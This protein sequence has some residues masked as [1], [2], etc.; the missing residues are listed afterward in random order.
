MLQQGVRL[1]K[2]RRLL[3]RRGVLV[4]YPTL[5][6]FA[7]AEFGFGRQATTIPL[8]DGEPGDELQLDTGWMTRL[9]PDLFGK[10]RR[11]R[12]WIFTPSRSRYRFVYP[13]FQETTATAIE[14]CE[15]AW[16]F[17]GG[18]FHTLVPD[19][20]SAI[21]DQADPLTPRINR[22]FLEYAQ[23]RHFLIDVARVRHP[24]DKGLDSY[25]TSCAA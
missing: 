16:A 10:R 20:T 9:E 6:R 15:A 2:I 8:A 3:Q 25:C 5:H 23:A 13:C 18:V 21:V 1:S 7:V 17:Y 12:A 24:R 19:N 14:A 4:P 11:F 22:T